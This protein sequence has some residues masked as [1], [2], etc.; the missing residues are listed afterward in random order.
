[1]GKERKSKHKQYR[2]QLIIVTKKTLSR[3]GSQSALEIFHYLSVETI[4]FTLA[5]SQE[6]A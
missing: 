1:M 4:S 2:G 6:R 5:F 3:Y